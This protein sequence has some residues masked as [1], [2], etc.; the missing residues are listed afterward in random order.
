[1][2]E[3]GW[4]LIVCL[5]CFGGN[6]RMGVFVI[7]FI[8]CFNLIGMLLVELKEVVCYKDSVILKFGS[9]DLVDG[10]LVVDIKLYFFFVELFF[11]VSVSYV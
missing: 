11:D 5:L 3:G 7:C 10:M 8:F 1:M 9:L 6:V 4:C 2:M